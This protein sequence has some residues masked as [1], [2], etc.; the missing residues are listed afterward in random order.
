MSK[1]KISKTLYWSPRIISIIFILFLAM[2]SLDVFDNC[3]SLWNCFLA[4]MIHNI[5]VFILIAL[6][7]WAWNREIVGA[8]MWGVAGS[9]YILQM[10]YNAWS[11]GGKWYMLSYSIIIAGP[12]FVLSYLFYKNWKYRKK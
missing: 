5:P 2:F 9:L 6:L 8:W 1:K 4:L 10:A 12:A 11:E 3:T 7:C